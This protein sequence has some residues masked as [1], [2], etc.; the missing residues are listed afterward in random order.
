MTPRMI[1]SN[2]K[3]KKQNNKNQND[4][5]ETPEHLKYLPLLNRN[6]YF[7]SWIFR[8]LWGFLL[9]QLVCRF[10]VKMK[11]FGDLHKIHKEHPRLLIVSNHSSHSDTACIA[12]AI[13]FK[14]WP[15]L[16][17]GAAK[18]YWFSNAPLTFFSKHFL[19]AI[20]INRKDKTGESIKFCISLFSNLKN[21]WMVLY[22]E[23]T[24]SQD[25]YIQS[26]KK[27][28]S[29]ISEEA[30]VPILFLYLEGTDKIMP[31]GRWPLPGTINVHIGPVQQPDKIKVIDKNYREW[32]MSINPKAYKDEKEDKNKKSKKNKG[33]DNNKY[34]KE[35]KG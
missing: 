4:K 5:S 34:Q 27:G 17:V 3:R 13:P 20:P 26:F 23:G 35:N 10:Y 9:K 24:R 25:G 11:I 1:G 14:F 15:N 6:S 28:V 32:V 19:G 8:S 7:I 33:E 16:Y 30:Q 18:D 12:A 29:L 2:M 21:I 31:K 22:P